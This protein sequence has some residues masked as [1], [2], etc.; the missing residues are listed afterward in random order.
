MD[1]KIL[2]LKEM[3]AGKGAVKLEA[4]L[5]FT[6]K[7]EDHDWVTVVTGQGRSLAV[8][9]DALAKS[10]KLSRVLANHLTTALKEMKA[11]QPKEPTGPKSS[12]PSG[13]G[14]PEGQ[15]NSSSRTSAGSKSLTP[16]PATSSPS[17]L[18]RVPGPAA[19]AL[20]PKKPGTKDSK[21]LGGTE[22]TASSEP[23][24]VVVDEF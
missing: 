20:A 6:R 19:T 21:I 16:K 1:I 22:Q 13:Q 5:S 14:V 18:S 3:P 9:A 2:S 11:D 24:D 4:Q 7:N 8:A 17:H 23:D 10:D 15:E 12:E